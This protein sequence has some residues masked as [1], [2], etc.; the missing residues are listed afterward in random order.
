MKWSKEIKVDFDNQVVFLTG[1]SRGIGKTIKENFEMNGASVIAPSREELNL[2]D[3]NSIN[4]YLNSNEIEPSVF[5]F[6]AAVNPKNVIENL[7]MDK[8]ENTFQVNLFSSVQ[9]LKHYIPKMKEKKSGKIVF[10]TSLYSTVTREGRI[11]YT[12]SKHAIAGLMKTLALE[13]APFDICVN[14]VAPGYVMTDMTRQNL[15]LKEIKEIETNI[16]TKRFQTEQEI[17]DVVMFLCGTQ[18]KSI[19]GQTIYVD[20]GFLCR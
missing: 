15:S 9:I 13:L 6:C 12:S 2:S 8:I 11:P 5:I 16:P 20:G 17:A 19:T 4:N 7:D 14:A 18:N 10:I 1:G 3:A